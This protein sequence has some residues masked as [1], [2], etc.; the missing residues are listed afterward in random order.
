MNPF[1]DQSDYKVLKEPE[2]TS[3]VKTKTA[4]ESGLIMGIETLLDIM[5]IALQDRKERNQN[6]LNKQ[7]AN[8]TPLFVKGTQWV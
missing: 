4:T 2:Y 1:V 8:A 7:S 3:K 6:S 5:S